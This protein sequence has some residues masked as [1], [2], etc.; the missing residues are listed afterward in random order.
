MNNH[1]G[2]TVGGGYVPQNGGVDNI[3][4]SNITGSCNLSNAGGGNITIGSVTVKNHSNPSYGDLTGLNVADNMTIGKITVIDPDFTN[5]LGVT[6]SY[7]GF[8][9]TTFNV[10]SLVIVRPR[11]VNLDA[12][13]NYSLF[14]GFTANGGTLGSIVIDNPSIGAHCKLI[15][16]EAY[17]PTGIVSLTIRDAYNLPSTNP[18]SLAA[19][20]WDVKW[21]GGSASNPVFNFFGS[22]NITLSFSNISNTSA[23]LFQNVE[24]NLTLI[25]PENYLAP[26]RVTPSTSGTVSTYNMAGYQRLIVAP[27]GTIAALTLDLPANPI[28]GEVLEMTFTQAVTALT[29]SG[30]TMTGIGSGVAAGFGGKWIYSA[31]DSKW[32]MFS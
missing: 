7:V 20:S 31:S 24:A 10:G 15:D 16:N 8:S 13:T 28:N 14:G 3:V 29:V 17:A 12:T 6:G 2:F 32:L 5:P 1:A 27:A 11:I 26:Q 21:I 19:G 18:V 4:I 30:G 25:N 22:D 9:S 23:Q